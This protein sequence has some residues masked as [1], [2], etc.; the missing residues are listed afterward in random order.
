MYFLTL[1]LVKQRSGLKVCDHHAV[2]ATCWPA[3]LILTVLLSWA[4]WDMANLSVLYGILPLVPAREFGC[5]C[6]VD[7]KELILW[8]SG[9]VADEAFVSRPKFNWGQA[10]ALLNELFHARA[11]PSV[12]SLN[13]KVLATLCQT[14]ASGGEVGTFWCKLPAYLRGRFWC[15]AV[16]YVPALS[17]NTLNYSLMIKTNNLSCTSSWFRWFSNH[18]EKSLNAS[19]VCANLKVS[20]DLLSFICMA[21]ILF[22]QFSTVVGLLLR[23]P[24]TV[25]CY[26]LTWISDCSWSKTGSQF[27]LGILQHCTGNK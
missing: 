10:E 3:C 24:P 21:S 14:A 25:L 9:L 17:A 23:L 22:A 12:F 1:K 27:L 11:V 20:L 19:Y 15:E 18:T 26:A 5:C 7:C 2:H 4:Q 13:E 8:R 16:F 6:S